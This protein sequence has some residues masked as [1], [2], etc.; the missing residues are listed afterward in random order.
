[1]K[2]LML[3]LL[4]VIFCLFSLTSCYFHDG[5]HYR[6]G[7]FWTGAILA[8]MFYPPRFYAPYYSSRFVR[9]GYCTHNYYHPFRVPPVVV[10]ECY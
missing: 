7:Y 10:Q 9:P 4:V 3:A 2:R 6:G 8:P 1:M 5:G